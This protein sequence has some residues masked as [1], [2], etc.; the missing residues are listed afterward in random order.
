M[1]NAKEQKQLKPSFDVESNVSLEKDS[2]ILADMRIGIH[3]TMFAGFGKSDRPVGFVRGG[4]SS[5]VMVPLA[6]GADLSEP[7]PMPEPLG[8][9]LMEMPSS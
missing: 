4:C 6:A 8:G 7:R 1:T 5:A 9:S 3:Q 2:P